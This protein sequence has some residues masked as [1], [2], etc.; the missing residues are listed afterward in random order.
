MNYTLFIILVII[1][2]IYILSLIFFGTFSQQLFNKRIDEQNIDQDISTLAESVEDNFEHIKNK[3]NFFTLFAIFIII[4]ILLIYYIIKFG[5]IKGIWRIIITWV[6]FTIA[7]PTPQS[8]LL[9]SI[10]LKLIY[11]IPMDLTQIIASIVCLI[12][13]FG[14]HFFAPQ[15]LNIG[16][17]GKVMDSVIKN[18]AYLVLISSS[19]GST[20]IS[21]LIDKIIDFC[22]LKKIQL[23]KLLSYFIL[24]IVSIVYYNEEMKKFNLYKYFQ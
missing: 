3:T 6:F 12:I 5:V 21:G 22:S 4:A 1:L 23:D 10:P 13:I 16:M 24:T 14:L 19:I 7:T 8:G 11:K 15:V 2:I 9:L 18:N 17:F 20:T